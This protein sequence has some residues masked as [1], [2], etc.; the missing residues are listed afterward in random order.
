[1]LSTANKQFIS[2]LEEFRKKHIGVAKEG[3]KK[4]DKHTA[5]FCQSQ[6]RYLNLSTK[7]Q[8]NVLIEADASVEMEQRAFYK[9]SL[10]YVFRLQ[11]V[12]ERKKFEFVET[13]LSFMYSWL[14]FYHHG[15]ETAKDFRPYMTNIQERV[16]KTRANFTAAH[17]KAET[18]MH[19]MLE[20]RKLTKTHETGPLSKMCTQQ[21]YLFL[22][23]KKALGTTWTKQYCQYQKEHKLFSM[24]PYSQTAGKMGTL[25]TFVLKSCTRRSSDSIEKRFCFDITADDRQGVYT[26]Q[27]L[28]EEDRQ[29]WLN[30]MDGKEPTYSQPDGRSSKSEDG[31]LDET[32]S[33]FVNKCM[34]AL[35]NRGLEEQ[36]LYRLVGVWSKVSKLLQMGLDKRKQ[37]KLNLDDA[38]DWECKTITSALKNYFRNLPEPLMTFRLHSAFI[39]AAKQECRKSRINDVHALVHNLPN[40]NMKMLKILIQH[41]RKVASKSDK[42]LMTVSNLGV[43]FGPTLLRPEEETMA[44]IMEIKFGNIVVEILIE[45]YEQIFNQPPEDSDAIK[46]LLSPVSSISAKSVHNNIAPSHAALLTAGIGMSGF[47][48]SLLSGLGTKSISTPGLMVLSS[49]VA[50][51]VPATRQLAQ[52]Q[53]PVTVYNS[54]NARS[55]LAGQNNVNG[56]N[57]SS[58]S[59]SVN[60]KSSREINYTHQPSGTAPSLLY[61]VDKLY[62]MSNSNARIPEERYGSIGKA[63]SKDSGISSL[64]RQASSSTS[65]LP[66]LSIQS[67]TR[68]VRTLFHCVGENES[69]LS[70]E[71]NQIITSVRPSREPGWLEG[72]LNGK[73]G[74]LPENYVEYLN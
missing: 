71:P 68:R 48:D 41:L 38:V 50:S 19:K 67:T 8:G 13:L 63:T 30:A 11:E 57:N 40:E 23:E 43:C 53:Q 5:K 29:S 66:S 25:E 55:L 34:S 14:T 26:L 52:P 6:E 64:M 28:S 1:M 20:V 74:L 51:P 54:I 45:N 62:M 32:G 16:Q 27:A 61:P 17:E 70:F 4:F 39:A 42:N 59:E 10:E 22:M 3:K 69:E 49:A 46:R 12:Q 24:I 37:E 21:G 2:P 47:D 33:V 31:Q 73:T 35:E 65:S 72:T 18:L 15:H 9:A 44:A 36:G 56:S 60:S 58:S 7:K